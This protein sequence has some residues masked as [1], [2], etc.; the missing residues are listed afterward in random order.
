VYGLVIA[1]L[2]THLGNMP[3]VVEVIFYIIAGLIWLWPARAL[4][5]WMLAG[6]LER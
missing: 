2:S 3:F 5:R 6:N 1:E 4:L